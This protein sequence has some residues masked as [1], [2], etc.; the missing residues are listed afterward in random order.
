MP[1][2]AQTEANCICIQPAW[3][4][5]IARPEYRVD[6]APSVR[7]LIQPHRRS[8]LASLA[9]FLPRLPLNVRNEEVNL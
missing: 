8:K 1:Y 3:S 2:R 9:S 5:G 4:D 7:A 6:S